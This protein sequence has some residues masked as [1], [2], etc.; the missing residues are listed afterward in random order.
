MYTAFLY[1]DKSSYQV[2]GTPPPTVS[3]SGQPIRYAPPTD[4]PLIGYNA[5]TLA[6][7]A[8]GKKRKITSTKKIFQKTSGS[9]SR[10][11][12]IESALN[13]DVPADA[14]PLRS[15]CNE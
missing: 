8:A 1:P 2:D 7:V 6:D 12:T 4:Y 10:T 13:A 15:E 5:P 14:T 3:R 9:S 11:L